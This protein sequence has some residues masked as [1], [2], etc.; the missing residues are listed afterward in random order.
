LIV[1]D[2][3]LFSEVIREVLTE[4][5]VEVAGTESTGDAA[6]AAARRLRPD[7]VLIDLA[8]PDRP[9]LE[10]G[11]S[12]LEELPE[13]KVVAVTGS[14]GEGALNGAISRGF[15]GFLSKDVSLREFVSSIRAAVDGNV[16][17]FPHTAASEANLTEERKNGL[18]LARQLS[19]REKELLALLVDGATSAE[20]AE[21]LSL[22][23]NTVRTH[24]QSILTKLQVHSRLEAAMFAVK[25]G[26]V[27]VPGTVVN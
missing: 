27:R 11:S 24:I 1:D 16:V 10:V 2:N 14:N 8:L 23:P 18:L 20:I 4:N 7:V 13:T 26:V 15:H 19:A 17:V 6:I 21:K 5:G 9:G 3:R 12:I 22:S 25:H